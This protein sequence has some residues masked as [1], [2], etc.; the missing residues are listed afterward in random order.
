MRRQPGGNLT[1]AALVLAAGATSC[2][3]TTPPPTTPDSSTSAPAV[4]KAVPADIDRDAFAST[5]LDEAERLDGTLATADAATAQEDV[6]LVPAVEVPDETGSGGD[7]ITSTFL[8]SDYPIEINSA[9]ETFL[10]AFTRPGEY[11]HRIVIGLSRAGRYLPMIRARLASAGL[12]NDLAYLPLIESAY[13]ETATSRARAQGLWQFIAGTARQYGLTVNAM[14][15]ERSDAE[16]ATEAAVAHLSDLYAEFGDWNLALAAYNSGAGNVRRAMRRS[17][18]NDFWAL[19]RYLPLETRNYVPAFMAAVLA[20]KEPA[21]YGLPEV[22]EID[23][24][25]DSLQVPDALDLDVLAHGLAL[26]PEELRRLNPAVRRGLTP[27]ETVTLVRL[28]AGS[29]E[30]AHAMLAQLPR[31]QWAPRMLHTVRTGESLSVIARRYGSSPE[32]IRAANGLRG[33]MIRPG[34]S[35]VVPRFG[36]ANGP[37]MPDLPR[38]LSTDGAYVVRSGDSLWAISRSF[39]V[40]LEA[41]CAANSLDRRSE[42]HPGQRVHI[43]AATDSGRTRVADAAP[44]RTY[45]VRVGDTLFDIARRFGTT[46]GELR[47]RNELSG[48]VIQPGDVLRIPSPRGA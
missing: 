27:A 43:P 11:R 29:A 10:D 16:R 13:S 26:T 36:S 31:N 41:L 44:K 21:R 15:D 3:T 48:N 38:N 35:L 24:Q 17:G 37:R 1:L 12:P 5:V 33:S 30:R 18:S 23:W 25:Y 42:L 46:V 40:S 14:I 39:G 28:P 22:T 4:A 8:T 6:N 47:R 34:Q 20:V 2:R 7:A 9:V 32:A 45:R 19:R